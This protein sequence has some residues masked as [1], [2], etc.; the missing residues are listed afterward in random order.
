MSVT[1]GMLIVTAGGELAVP[2]PQR[3]MGAKYTRYPLASPTLAKFPEKNRHQ[4]KDSQASFNFHLLPAK[5]GVASYKNLM[6]DLEYADR[7]PISS[8][9]SASQPLS[10]MVSDGGFHRHRPLGES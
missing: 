2:A 8:T 7:W 4:G 10:Q 5:V 3:H 1:L 6:V 9:L